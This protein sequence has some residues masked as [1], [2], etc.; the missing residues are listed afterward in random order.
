MESRHTRTEQHLHVGA[1]PDEVTYPL[2]GDPRIAGL[3]PAV[4]PARMVT[5]QATP[6]TPDDRAPLVR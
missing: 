3:A 6:V 4:R 5:R 2:S 1:A